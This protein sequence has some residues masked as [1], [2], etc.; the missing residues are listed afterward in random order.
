[1]QVDSIRGDAFQLTVV[2]QQI[3]DELEGTQDRAGF[4]QETVDVQAGLLE[5]LRHESA[6][7]LLLR[8]T[9][10]DWRCDGCLHK[11]AQCTAAVMSAAN[12]HLHVRSMELATSGL[13]ARSTEDA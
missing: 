12:A 11:Q 2:I 13:Q 8:Q 9:F 4:L 7:K 10:V 1:M 3:K 6:H 5:Q